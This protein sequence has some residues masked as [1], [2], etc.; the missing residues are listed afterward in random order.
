VLTLGTFSAIYSHS[1][2][3][4]GLSVFGSLCCAVWLTPWIV[5]R[6]V[7]NKNQQDE[8]DGEISLLSTN[9]NSVEYYLTVDE[10][11]AIP[12]KDKLTILVNEN[13]KLLT[14]E[15]KEE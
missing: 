15:E 10:P 3:L 9:N 13:V 12:Y 6:L 1:D 5:S 7:L 14:G 8:V 4:T 2:I 11:M